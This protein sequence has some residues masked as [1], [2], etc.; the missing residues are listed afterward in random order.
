M[1]TPPQICNCGEVSIANATGALLAIHHRYRPAKGDTRA[2]GG[3]GGLGLLRFLVGATS[4]YGGGV[5]LGY[6]GGIDATCGSSSGDLRLLLFSTMSASGCSGGVDAPCGGGSVWLDMVVVRV[7]CGCD[8]VGGTVGVWFLI[9]GGADVNCG[10]LCYCWSW[11]HDVIVGA[12]LR[13][14]VGCL[15]SVTKYFVDL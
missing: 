7:C 15:E 4:R 1:Q 10:R 5:A 3:N 8:G 12:G 6:G 13:P 2:C 14:V 9:S 11:C